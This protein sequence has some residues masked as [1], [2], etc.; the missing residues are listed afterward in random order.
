MEPFKNNPT[1]KTADDDFEVASLLSE[2]E[3]SF[4]YQ[5]PVSQRRKTPMAI[6]L[7][8]WVLN[9]V[10][11]TTTLYFM[12]K[13]LAKP[14]D[15]SQLSYSTFQTSTLRVMLDELLIFCI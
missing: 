7:L 1:H 2:S 15:P 8:P 11:I 3:S 4:I 12:Q 6:V 13:S 5:T 9:A 10:F 14:L